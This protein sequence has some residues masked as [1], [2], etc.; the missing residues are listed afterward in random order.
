MGKSVNFTWKWN[1]W[2]TRIVVVYLVINFLLLLQRWDVHVAL[3]VHV[4][5]PILLIQTTAF[6]LNNSSVTV[7]EIDFMP[8][9]IFSWLKKKICLAPQK[10]KFRVHLL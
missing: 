2:P 9:F 3:I 4:L 6:S 10:V 7:S 5:A 1:N 8:S